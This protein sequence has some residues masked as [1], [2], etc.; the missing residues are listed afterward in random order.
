MTYVLP[1]VAETIR[2]T[3]SPY[4]EHYPVDPTNAPTWWEGGSVYNTMTRVRAW[5]RN[6]RAGWMPVMNGR[7]RSM[8]PID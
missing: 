7:K 3:D 2:V 8:P 1:T 4:G 5:D 6:V